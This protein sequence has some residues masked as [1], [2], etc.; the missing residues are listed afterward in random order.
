MDWSL[1]QNTW[2]WMTHQT[3]QNSWSEY[4]RICQTVCLQK[5][6]LG[7]RLWDNIKI[8]WAAWIRSLIMLMLIMLNVYRLSHIAEIVYLYNLICTFF[9]VCAGTT[10]NWWWIFPGFPPG[11]LRWHDGYWN[12]T[13]SLICV[14]NINNENSIDYVMYLGGVVVGL[15]QLRVPLFSYNHLVMNKATFSQRIFDVL[16]IIFLDR[17]LSYLPICL[18]SVLFS[19]L[20]AVLVICRTSWVY[21]SVAFFPARVFK[22]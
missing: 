13:I 22:H 2:R 6:I 1:F 8:R 10:V 14:E 7:M 15:I 9:F 16:R 17:P 12:T 20:S 4:R 19:P 21:R 18:P 11:F 3:I 5:K